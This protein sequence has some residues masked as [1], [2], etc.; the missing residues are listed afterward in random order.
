MRNKN[1]IVDSVR[2][3]PKDSDFLDRKIGSRG[4]VFF[5]PDDKTLRIFDGIVAGGIPLLR[6]DLENLTAQISS[7]I[8]SETAPA[9]IDEGTIWFNSTNGRLYIY[10]N[11]G[12]SSQWVQPTTPSYGS[13]GGG[14]GATTLNDLTD[15]VINSATNGQVLKYNGSA[16]V[17][18]TISAGSTNL[19]GLTDVIITNPESGQSL[20]Y[21]GTNWVNTVGVNSISTGTGIT[22]SGATGSITLTNT[23]VTSILAGENITI[24]NST[25]AVTI[26]AVVGG[27]G[28]GITLEEAQD[29]AA[30]LFLNGTH[31]GITFTYVDASNAINAVIADV[32]LGTRTSGNYVA[33]VQTGSG[34]TG[35]TAGS[36]GAALT[37]GV[38]TGIVATLTGSQVLTNKTISGSNNT[39]SNIANASL[40]NSSITINGQSVSLGGTVTI[41]ASTSLDGLTDVVITSASVGQILKYNGTNWVNDT[42]ST[43]G[44]VNSF[45]NIEISGQTTVSADSTNDTLTF[46]GA[47]GITISTNAGTDTITFTGPTVPTTINGLTDASSASIT[48]DKIAYQ[49]IARLDVTSSGSSAYLFN[50]HYSGNNPTLYAISGTTIAFNLQASGHPFLIQDG[51]GTNYNTGLV[52]VST[53]GTVST[54]SSAQGKDSGTLYWQIPAGISGN[55]RYQCS[56]H[57][58]MVG[59]ITVKGIASI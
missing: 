4:E 12:N 47:N 34:L 32:P 24:S 6:A 11:D 2:I 41:S 51:T 40:Q 25:G 48:I 58:P 1:P 30:T 42:D 5:D 44:S 7:V 31:T 16:W 28:G 20:R 37:I 10:Y 35:G 43:G 56:A 52:H 9:G 39:I 54:G 45:A 19:D 27:G 3:L 26:S 49:A 55:Y 38:D 59:T 46:V 36:E 21:N 15:V 18:D 29:G 14:G 33:S 23:G 13:G 57:A 50:S 8:V 17:N 22:A 53:S